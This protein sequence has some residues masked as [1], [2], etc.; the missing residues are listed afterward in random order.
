MALVLYNLTASSEGSKLGERLLAGAPHTDEQCMATINADDA[1][2]S[3]QMFQ[4]IIKEYQVHPR[5]VL[6]VF[7]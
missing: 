4:S 2:H 1:V 5:L 3:G 7:L 6:I